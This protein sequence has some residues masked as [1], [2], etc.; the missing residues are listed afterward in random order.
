MRVTRHGTTTATSTATTTTTTSSTNNN[1]NNN[2]NNYYYYY[3][4]SGKKTQSYFL[5]YINDAC[6][7]SYICYTVQNNR[8]M[9]SGWLSRYS[10]W[11][12]VGRSG[13]LI[14]VG[15]EIFRSCPDRLWGP[16]SLLYSVYRVFPG[17]RKRP[18]RD[19]DPPPPSSTEV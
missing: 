17:G 16:P 14:P 2:N 18:G 11:L 1:N 8:T 6:Q 7:Q 12:R 15:G 9:W 3:L 10:D 13:D 4:Q 19:A 5:I